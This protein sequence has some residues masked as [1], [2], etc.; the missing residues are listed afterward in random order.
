METV[1]QIRDRLLARFPGAT[2]TRDWVRDAGA[3][4]SKVAAPGRDSTS[5]TVTDSPPGSGTETGFFGCIADWTSPA[6]SQRT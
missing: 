4:T 5:V 1:E 6:C 2:V 3:L